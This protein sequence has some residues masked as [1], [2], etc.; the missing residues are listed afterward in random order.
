MLGILAL[1]YLTDSPEKA[2]WLTP[3][4]RAWLVGEMN[5]ERAAGA[6]AERADVRRALTSGVTWLLALL[7]LFALSAELGPIFFGPDSRSGRARAR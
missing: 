1:R 5:R 6:G 4:Q 2:G 3:E 7:Y